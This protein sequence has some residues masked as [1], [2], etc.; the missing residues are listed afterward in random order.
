MSLHSQQ[1]KGLSTPARQYS[2]LIILSFNPR[3]T[4]WYQ[5]WHCPSHLIINSPL[6][7]CR[8]RQYSLCLRPGLFLIGACLDLPGSRSP[9]HRLRGLHNFSIFKLSSTNV[10]GLLHFL[11]SSGSS[12]DYYEI[13]DCSDPL[14]WAVMDLGDPVLAA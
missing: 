14:H 3:Q 10:M 12:G 7:F 5:L 1:K 11:I 2:C 4:G 8:H 6:S 9:P 13:V